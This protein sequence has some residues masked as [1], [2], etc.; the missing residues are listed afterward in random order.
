MRPGPSSSSRKAAL[1]A[2]ERSRKPQHLTDSLT[3]R[4]NRTALTSTSSEQKIGKP[5]TEWSSLSRGHADL[6]CIYPIE[7][8]RGLPPG[9]PEAESNR[10]ARASSSGANRRRAGRPKTSASAF[11]GLRKAHVIRSAGKGAG[12]PV[13][14]KPY[15]ASSILK[16]I[17][18]SR[19]EIK[20]AAT[21][22]QRQH[23]SRI[24]APL[25][26]A[27]QLHLQMNVYRSC[28]VSARH[29]SPP[30]RRIRAPHKH[31]HPSVTAYRIAWPSGATHDHLP[32]SS[33]SCKPP[34]SGLWTLLVVT[35]RSRKE[36][37]KI[38]FWRK[39]KFIFGQCAEPKPKGRKLK[40][41]L[42]IRRL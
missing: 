7:L 10:L 42:A 40:G 34:L 29:Q 11:A 2:R 9:G 20:E 18:L 27:K 37:K 26:L 24:T 38:F 5:R 22:I 4:P 33:N 35:L 8:C 25:A 30:R 23:G 41:G 36:R 17:H 6:L 32:K 3:P 28:R 15:A 14:A 13:T 21:S 16:C 31:S 1:A 19:D 39:K 12:C